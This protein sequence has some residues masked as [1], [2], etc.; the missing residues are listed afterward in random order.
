MDD[1]PKHINAQEKEMKSICHPPPPG[2]T[3][4]SD[5]FG[6]PSVGPGDSLR[7]FIVSQMQFG[8]LSLLLLP[9][10]IMRLYLHHELS[11]SLSFQALRRFLN[12]RRDGL[13]GIDIWGF[14][15]FID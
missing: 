6:V 10:C 5:P 15:V 7:S 13:C 3:W 1:I 11:L 12:L 14:S 2:K 8:C 9:R 4:H